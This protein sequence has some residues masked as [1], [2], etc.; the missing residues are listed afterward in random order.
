MSEASSD[1][2]NWQMEAES[3]INDVK[4]HVN[5]LKISQ[6]LGSS[7]QFIYLNLRTIE[8]EEF[9]IELSARGFRI[10]GRSFD[11]NSIDSD[12]YFETPYSLLNSVSK[13]FKDSF[14]NALL[15]KLGELTYRLV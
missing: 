5:E 4:D 13:K 8:N 6:K 1:L 14:G 11:T 15:E 2:E 12:E 7:N 3:V 10:V 9:C